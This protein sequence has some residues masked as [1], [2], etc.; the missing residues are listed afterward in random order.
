MLHIHRSLGHPQRAIHFFES[1][2][3]P[4]QFISLHKIAFL[5]FSEAEGGLELTTVRLAEELQQRGA[6]TFVVTL[7]ESSLLQWTAE[8][9]IPAVE[10]KPKMKYGDIVCARR[11]GI[12]LR[13]QKIE[14]VIVMRSSDIHLA[15]LAKIWYPT[16]CL[17]FYQQMQ[18]GIN[19]RDILHTWL[20]SHLN[21]WMTLTD[22]MRVSVPAE[23][24]NECR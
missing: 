7:P 4:V 1:H 12:F 14:A 5:C 17:V 6:S 23:Y 11:L 15:V 8:R 18:S 16:L 20:Y 24:T 10:L 2:A 21:L 9:Q 19:K 13:Q 3:L 22:S